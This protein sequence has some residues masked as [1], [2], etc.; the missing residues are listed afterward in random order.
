MIC[1][2][3]SIFCDYPQPRVRQRYSLVAQQAKRVMRSEKRR[4]SHIN[5]SCEQ[6]IGSHPDDSVS[7]KV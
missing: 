5:L 3:T 7:E 1:L 4:I 2:R 6:P